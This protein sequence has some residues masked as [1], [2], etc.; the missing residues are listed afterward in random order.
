MQPA[1]FAEADVREPRQLRR[2]GA[3]LHLAGLSLNDF[4]QRRGHPADPRRP[5][6][7]INWKETD[8]CRGSKIGLPSTR[9]GELEAPDY[10]G[11]AAGSCLAE[12]VSKD[13]E[14]SFH[15]CFGFA[16]VL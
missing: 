11:R 15:A 10:H 3:L 7:L 14:V 6:W 12:I 2:H 5:R 13:L 1:A 8:E 4:A 16:S 9:G